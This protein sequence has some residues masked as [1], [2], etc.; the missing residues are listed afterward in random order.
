[1]GWLVGEPGNRASIKRIVGFIMFYTGIYHLILLVG[2]LF[3]RRRLTILMYH[4]IRNRKGDGILLRNFQGQMAYLSTNCNV[5]SLDEYSQICSRGER[6]P[7]NSVS[8]T[9]DDGF[10]DNYEMAFPVLKNNH[11]S[12]TIFLTTGHLDSDE[13]FWWDKIAYI[14]QNTKIKSFSLKGLGNY[15]TIDKNRVIREIQEKVKGIDEKKKEVLI[16][17]LQ[18]RLRVKVPKAKGQF[19]SWDNVR[20]MGKNNITFGAHTV[21]HPILTRVTLT[22]AR[23]EITDSRERIEKETGKRVTLFAYPNGKK[24]DMDFRIDRF[25][26]EQGFSHAVTTIHGTNK[27]E[28][29]RLKRIGIGS[30]DD[31]RFF[32]I[33]LSSIGEILGPIGRMVG[34]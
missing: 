34:I 12:A 14:I 4:R 32:R 17:E 1:M 3:D 20:K 15:R 21:S 8:I 9:F 22:D 16:R 13:L 29:F 28:S 19:L 2:R 26:K 24:E 18:K 31:L 25:L 5:I 27:C 11:L 6:L 23:R 30:D 7:R 33:K 10:K